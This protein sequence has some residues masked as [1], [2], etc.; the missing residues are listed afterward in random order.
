MFFKGK[1]VLVSGG[2][3]FIGSNLCSRLI[4]EGADL[5][6]LVKYN[7]VVENIRLAGWW[8]KIHIV[9]ADIRNP[10]SLRALEDI[11]PEIVFHLAA[12]NH[13]GDSFF[14]ITEATDC[15][16]RG[17]VNILEAWQDYER[18]VY[19]ST[20]EVYGFQEEVPFTEH[21]EP[22]PLSPYAIGKYSGELYARMKHRSFDKPIAIL[23]PFNAYGPYRA[24]VPLPQK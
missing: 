18:F 8:D 15:N 5:Y 9:E 22:Q 14:H 12:Y 21:N 24:H 4:Q 1:R 10:D 20:S 17:T 19:I 6:V 11:K 2:S 16:F 3:G 13:V 23:R 7:S